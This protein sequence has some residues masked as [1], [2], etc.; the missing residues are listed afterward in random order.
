MMLVLVFIVV[1]L[2]VV[3][4]CSCSVPTFGARI[5]AV[6][7]VKNSTTTFI[8]SRATG[9]DLSSKSCGKL[10]VDEN[11]ALLT[12]SPSLSVRCLEEKDVRDIDTTS[13]ISLRNV[14]FDRLTQAPFLPDGT[15][16]EA[17]T[18]LTIPIDGGTLN[19]TM[20]AGGSFRQ[21][22]YSGTTKTTQFFPFFASSTPRDG[23]VIVVFANMVRRIDVTTMAE[24]DVGFD[25]GGG[26]HWDGSGVPASWSSRFGLLRGIAEPVDSC[27][28]GSW[29][30][31][32]FAKKKVDLLRIGGG[33]GGVQQFDTRTGEIIGWS[34]GRA[35]PQTNDCR[36][37][38]KSSV[39]SLDVTESIR[40]CWK[41]S[42]SSVTATETATATH[43]KASASA[44]VFA[45]S[46]L[47][48][49][50]IKV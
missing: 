40:K 17:N 29:K 21:D 44:V 34:S 10:V 8:L 47:L 41:V 33:C 42:S 9:S 2:P 36:T 43:N 31:V 23:F 46:L 38:M 28:G 16:T 1:L 24:V 20:P 13:L 25:F 39:E 4:G 18:V 48:T 27:G 6:K 45:M 37:S 22:R 49:M 14:P 35:F 12:T 32:D 5:H 7:A 19:T 11:V 30:R 3:G 26:S 15:E 50:I